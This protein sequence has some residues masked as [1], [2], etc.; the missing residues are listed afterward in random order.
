MAAIAVEG[1]NVLRE[2]AGDA[3]VSL[4]KC[5]SLIGRKYFNKDCHHHVV[6]LEPRKLQIKN[7]DIEDS[8]NLR[9]NLLVIGHQFTKFANVF[10]Y[11][12]YH[13]NLRLMKLYT[14]RSTKILE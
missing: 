5:F 4:F 11:T 14:C 3:K 10:H 7:T 1:I 9:E 8:V 2:P 6:P 12:V 13:E